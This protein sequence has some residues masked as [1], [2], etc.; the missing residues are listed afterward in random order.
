MNESRAMSGLLTVPVTVHMETLT[1]ADEVLPRTTQW[2]RDHG[3]RSKKEFAIDLL[4]LTGAEEHILLAQVSEILSRGSKISVHEYCQMAYTIKTHRRPTTRRHP[5]TK[6]IRPPNKNWPRGFKTRHETIVMLERAIW[7]GWQRDDV[8]LES[9]SHE[10]AA[11]IFDAEQLCSECARIKVKLKSLLGRRP[12]ATRRLHTF[13]VLM[14]KARTSSCKLCHFVL[15]SIDHWKWPLVTKYHLN[16]HQMHSVVGPTLTKENILL[17]LS[18]NDDSVKEKYTG[19][20]VPSPLGSIGYPGVCTWGT[21]GKAVNFTMAKSALDCCDDNH[22]TTCGLVST[23]DIPFFRLIDCT[24]RSLVDD[25]GHKK[26]AALSYCWGPPPHPPPLESSALP[27]TMSLVIEDALIVC[28]K[29]D[30]PYIWIDR[31]CIAQLNKVIKPI[32]LENMHKVYRSAYVTIVAAGGTSPDFGLAGVSSRERTTQ[33]SINTH[34]H[35]LI[36]IPNVAEE[37]RT[38]TW[39][40]RG[41]TLQENLLSRRRLVFTET[42]TYFQCRS[43]HCCEAIPIC[44]K[45]AHVNDMSKF[46]ESVKLYRV[47]P[48]QGIGKTGLE[49][50]ARIREYLNRSLTEDSDALIDF[51][52]IFQAYQE[53]ESPVYNFW[54]LP[55]STSGWEEVPRRLSK[56]DHLEELRVSFL[57]SLVWSCGTCDHPEMPQLNRRSQFPSWTWAAWKGLDTFVRRRVANDM[58]SPTVSFETN[59]GKQTALEEYEKVIEGCSSILLFALWVW[60]EG[61]STHVRFE[62]VAQRDEATTSSF[63]I[64]SPI[65]THQVTLFMDV[66]DHGRLRRR[67][68]EESVRVLIIGNGASGQNDSESSALSWTDVHAIVLLR[69]SDGVY[70]RLGI[71]TWI[72]LSRPR[73]DVTRQVLSVKKLF[74]A[75]R[76]VPPCTCGCTMTNDA[77]FDSYLE[78]GNQVMEFEKTIVKLV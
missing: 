75:R 78:F 29:L 14:V 21:L 20:I 59:E 49:I 35:R 51:L 71:V 63:R 62:E 57:S 55:M 43:M 11:T 76:V 47:F 15:A 16:V 26:Y 30:I 25:V 33:V 53:L 13:R 19:W 36:C 58:H 32:Q 3:R 74:E 18:I 5:C 22:A 67:L 60:L 24:T 34:G 61:W 7:L 12:N 38:C 64:Q 41:W 56:A 1:P 10:F 40:E 72:R 52:G 54:G 48:Q 8:C 50:D 27:L 77:P 37:I 42:Q 28:R 44:L 9:M 65:P 23:E 6:H 17:S 69:K 31:Y 39:S 45:K 73:I 46:K 4:Y 2:Y 66:S 70:S 68:L